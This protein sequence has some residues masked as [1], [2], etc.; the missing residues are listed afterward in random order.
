[1]SS[2]YITERTSFQGHGDSIKT[3]IKL[4]KFSAS[5]NT[6]KILS[7]TLYYILFHPEEVRLND[8]HELFKSCFT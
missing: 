4:Y 2:R 7:L 1:M 5:K 8:N 6:D 3:S